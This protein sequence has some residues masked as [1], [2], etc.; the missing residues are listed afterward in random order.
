MKCSES[1]S[2]D[3]KIYSGFVWQ[4]IYIVA[5]ALLIIISITTLSRLLPPSDF[6][7]MAVALIFV[8]LSSILSQIGVGQAIV[9]R[10]VISEQHVRVGFTLSVILGVLLMHLLIIFAKSI[11]VVFNDLRLSEILYWVAFS[12]F[13]SS[14]SSV[15][16]GILT[17]ELQFRTLVKINLCS[18]AIGNVLTSIILALAGLGV[19]SLAIGIVLQSAIKFFLCYFAT[20]HSIKPLLKN[21]ELK[22]LMYF[23]GGFTIARLFNYGATQGDNFILGL[24]AN[25]TFLGLYNRAY[26]IMMLPVTYIGSSVEKLIFPLMSRRQSDMVKLRHTYLIGTSLTCFFVAPISAI[27]FI[28]SDTLVNVLLGPQWG[29]TVKPLE[30]LS[31]SIIFRTTYK[32]GDS[33]AK[34][35]GAV[36]ARSVREG[37][38]FLCII[39]STILGLNWGLTGVA[40]G[41]FASITI[42]F[43]MTLM[44]SM[45]ILELNWSQ[46][47]KPY[48]SGLILLLISIILS[49]CLK[50]LLEPIV[51]ELILLLL[52][53]L[54]TLLLSLI[55]YCFYPRLLDKENIIFIKGFL[56]MLPARIKNN[57]T[58]KVIFRKF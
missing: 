31:L 9:Q 10:E 48:L 4:N 43:I 34:S 32:I 52:N 5:N 55:L 13:F 36:Y 15:S 18:F 35:V 33:L 46:I 40:I 30:I 53:S 12:F 23:G 26:Q 57:N 1:K 2:I 45:K 25:P 50:H 37:I 38:Y 8:N 21:K 56:K 19:F 51:N 42:N 7:L 11:S 28:N 14:A 16:E 41:V 20:M 22:E 39:A 58:L 24:Y 3:R 27:I 29:E 6:G 17:R 49:Y 54:L 44:M 47:L